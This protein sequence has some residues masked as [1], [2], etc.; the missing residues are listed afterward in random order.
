MSIEVEAEIRTSPGRR[1]SVATRRVQPRAGM[2][3][4]VVGPDGR[5][6]PDVLERLPGRGLW[7]EA[8]RDLLVERKT[9]KALARSGARMDDPAGLAEEVAGALERRCLDLLG[10][11]KRGRQA[12]AGYEKV[13]EAFARGKVALLFVARDAG[14][15]ARTA[16]H[17]LPPGTRRVVAFDRAQQGRALGREDAVFVAVLRGRLARKLE[18]ELVRLAGFREVEMIPA[19]GGEGE[20]EEANGT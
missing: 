11:A 13:K 1:R 4:F 9:Q 12:V 10:L 16:F 3:R 20:A 14:R 19:P 6:V 15:D 18:R 5:L 17:R 8:R 7:L 2:V